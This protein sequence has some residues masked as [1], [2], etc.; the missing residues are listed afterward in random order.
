MLVINF[1]GILIYGNSVGL[2]IRPPRGPAAEMTYGELLQREGYPV[3]NLSRA[4][5]LISEAFRTFDD[6]VVARFPSA[7]VFQFGVVEVSRRHFPRKVWLETVAYNVFL[8]QGTGRSFPL[9]PVF[10][11]LRRS[12]WVAARWFFGTVARITKYSWQWI[13]LPGFLQVQKEMLEILF[14]ETSAVAVVIG[15]NPCSERIEASLPGS[16]K[17]ISQAND[18]LRNLVAKFPR[19]VFLD[20]RD[21]ISENVRDA[22]VSDGVHYSAMG[23]R[24]VANRLIEALK[25]LGIPPVH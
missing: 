18:A 2:R 7:V 12:V 22:L 25:Y 4:G 14:K 1:V 10:R 20:P 6:D 11:R 13:P 24:L 9:N 19:A 5:V 17:A 8:N 15:V 3:R 16:S 21:F 23:H